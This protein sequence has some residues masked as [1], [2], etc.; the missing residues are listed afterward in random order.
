METLR[1]LDP[2]PS[3]LNPSSKF[4]LESA[5]LLLPLVL[6]SLCFGVANAFLGTSTM[7]AGRSNAVCELPNRNKQTHDP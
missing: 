4:A 2:R 3:T 7:L 1:N 5:M 6:V